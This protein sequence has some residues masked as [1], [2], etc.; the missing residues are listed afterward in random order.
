MFHLPD[1]DSNFVKKIMISDE[2]AFHVLGEINKNVLTL[3][4]N[5]SKIAQ[6]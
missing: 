4:R 6:K 2:A 3:H 5:T 1:N